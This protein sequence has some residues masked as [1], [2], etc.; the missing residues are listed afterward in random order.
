MGTYNNNCQGCGCGPAIPEP[1]ITPPPVCLDPQPCTEIINAQCVVYTGPA[2]TCKDS[3]IIPTNSSLVEALEAI[4]DYICLGACCSIPAVIEI[5]NPDYIVLCTDSTATCAH[6]GKLYNWYTLNVGTAGDGRTA[7]GIV[8]I[9]PLDN[10]IN[11]WRVPNNNDWYALALA[12]DPAATQTPWLN[13]A[14]GKIKSTTCWSLPNSGATNSS[15]LG[16][17]P[18]VVRNATTGFFATNNGQKSRYWSGN[19]NTATTYAFELDYI[20]DSLAAINPGSY[21]FGYKVRL[22]RPIDCNETDGDFISNAYKDNDGNLYNAEVIGN[23]VWLNSDLI[24]TKYNDAAPISNIIFDAP[25]I[26]ATTGAWCYPNNSST[27][28]ITY[29]DGC[30]QVKIAFENFLDFIP[31]STQTFV[32]AAGAGIQVNP[33][34]V[35]AQTT[36]TVTN[37]DPGSAQNIFKNVAVA[38]QPTIVADTNNDTLTVVSGTGIAVT[39]NPA[40]DELTITNSDLGSSQFIFKNIAVATQ[41]TVVA[42]SNNDTLTFVAGAGISITTDSATDEI[43][44]INADPGSGVV[45]ADAGTTAH[46]SLVNDGNGPSL[47]TKGLKAGTG[48]TL[49]STATDVTIDGLDAN[50][51]SVTL[52]PLNGLITITHGFGAFASIT[53]YVPK[54]GA[55]PYLVLANG[56]DYVYTTSAGSLDIISISGAADN[57]PV[58]VK[59]IGS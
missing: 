15:G 23:L 30:Q 44:I 8:N 37:T 41:P 50:V 55:F 47:A 22:V 10:Q 12:L 25:W 38:T 34:V 39:T 14:G 11:T 53:I 18:T 6:V 57:K 48:I 20:T 42:D 29:V 13:H 9:N 7:G 28:T 36:Y 40:T 32:V 2:I 56:I 43:T 3:P 45:L 16:V 24:D 19:D 51:F 35:G 46:E 59:I 5:D 58:F 1:C 49:S 33:N 21:G 52:A 4:V 54:A 31:T 17:S 27:F 26:A